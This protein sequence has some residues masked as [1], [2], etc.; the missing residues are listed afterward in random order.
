MRKSRVAPYPSPDFSDPDLLTKEV[1]SG[2]FIPAIFRELASFRSPM[3]RYEASLQDISD[4]MKLKGN[5]NPQ[6]IDIELHDEGMGWVKQFAWL[7]YFESDMEPEPEVVYDPM[8]HYAA[9]DYSPFGRTELSVP[10]VENLFCN[11]PYYDKANAGLFGYREERDSDGN[12]TARYL[13]FYSLV[14]GTIKEISDMS[15]IDWGAIYNPGYV[16]GGLLIRDG[17]SAYTYHFFSLDGSRYAFPSCTGN[18]VT[19]GDSGEFA[20]EDSANTFIYNAK[21]EEIGRVGSLACG[22]SDQLING[23]TPYPFGTKIGRTFYYAKSENESWQW[24]KE[25]GKWK[26]RIVNA[27]IW[28]YS[29][30]T[31]YDYWQDGWMTDAIKPFG[32]NL[33]KNG[34]FVAPVIP[35]KKPNR[36]ECDFRNADRYG[37]FI[38]RTSGGKKKLLHTMDFRHWEE[39]PDEAANAFYEGQGRIWVDGR[40]DNIVGFLPYAMEVRSYSSDESVML[41]FHGIIF[42]G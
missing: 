10:Y 34:I 30:M 20:I 15:D 7:P 16:K 4:A 22:S 24:H 13:M 21:G 28:K 3:E 9:A 17:T 18:C 27:P 8:K 41:T 25:K 29:T 11:I 33:R 31:K 38:V 6:A 40:T 26:A 37:D 5:F 36:P 14:N 23:V 1:T 42:R 2:A 32:Y 35:C 19:F 12:V 39:F